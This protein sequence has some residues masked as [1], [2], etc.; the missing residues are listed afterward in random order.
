MYTKVGEKMMT[1]RPPEKLAQWIR[2]KAKETGIPINSWLIMELT[3]LK[4]KEE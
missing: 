4:E 2:E 1:F 3:R